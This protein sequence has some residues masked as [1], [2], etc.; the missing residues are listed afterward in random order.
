MLVKS[1]VDIPS[2]FDTDGSIF[3]YGLK[4]NKIY[5]VAEKHQISPA[6]NNDECIHIL[7]DDGAVVPQDPNDFLTVDEWREEK[8]NDLNI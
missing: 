2:E 7:Y 8:L 4:K 6:P 3:R 5:K 1:K